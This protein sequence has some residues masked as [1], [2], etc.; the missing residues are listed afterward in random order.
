[1]GDILLCTLNYQ[2]NENTVQHNYIVI[3]IKVKLGFRKMLHVLTWLAHQQ[4][5]KHM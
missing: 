2:Y 4:A 5:Y 3:E 1:M